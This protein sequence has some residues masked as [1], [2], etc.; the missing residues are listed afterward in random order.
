MAKIDPNDC[1]IIFDE[2]L[3]WA[4]VHDIIAQRR[5]NSEIRSTC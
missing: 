5:S 1:C 2:C 4:L 3:F